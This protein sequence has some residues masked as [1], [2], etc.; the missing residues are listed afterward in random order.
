MP[1]T[2]YYPPLSD[3]VSIDD[4]PDV[5]SFIKDGIQLLFDDIYY[6]DLQY[7]KSLKGDPILSR[8]DML[9]II[10]KSIGKAIDNF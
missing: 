7:S 6:N 5:L 1:V 3:V 10:K 8:I 4:L 9:N 2:K